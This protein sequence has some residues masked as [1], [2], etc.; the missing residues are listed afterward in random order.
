VHIP[1]SST[2][3][4]LKDSIKQKAPTTLEGIGAYKLGLFKVSIPDEDDLAQ[5]VKDAIQGAVPLPPIRK[6]RD[7]FPNPS[8]ETI[9][10]AVKLPDDGESC[11]SSFDLL[12][13]TDTVFSTLLVIPTT[14]FQKHETLPVDIANSYIEPQRLVVLLTLL[15]HD[16]TQNATYITPTFLR[17][18][19]PLSSLGKPWSQSSLF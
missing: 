4:D 13:L 19:V 3:S 5:K 18:F 12:S 2:V 14:L 7:L 8:E 16:P 17:F 6:I 1:G 15:A 10:V 9:H 11:I